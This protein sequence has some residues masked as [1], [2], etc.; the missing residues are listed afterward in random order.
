MNDQPTMTK[1]LLKTENNMEID[2]VF[3]M[4]NLKIIGMLRLIHDEKL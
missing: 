2:C 1:N 4:C 3:A